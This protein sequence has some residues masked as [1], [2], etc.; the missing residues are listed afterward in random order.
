MR[1]HH[2]EQLETFARAIDHMPSEVDHQVRDLIGAC[3]GAGLNYEVFIEGP[4][5]RGIDPPRVLK[6][7]WGSY[8]DRRSI[9]LPPKGTQAYE[10]HAAYCFCEEKDIWIHARG[11]GLLR[12]AS[13]YEDAYGNRDLPRYVAY[14]GEDS[15]ASIVKAI[16]D[17]EN[18]SR[19]IG[20]FTIES[21][22]HLQYN[23]SAEK[24]LKHLSKIISV[25][26]RT[27]QESWRNNENTRTVADQLRVRL[28]P[29]GVFSTFCQQ[30][31]IFHSHSSRALPDVLEIVSEAVKDISEMTKACH[32]AGFAYQPWSD[33]TRPRNIVTDLLETLRRSVAGIAYLSEPGDD[34]FD[35]NPNVLFEAGIMQALGSPFRGYLLIREISSSTAI[36]FD[37]AQW[38]TILVQRDRVDRSITNRE[39][40][41]DQIRKALR[42]VLEEEI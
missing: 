18:D 1:V 19:V 13:D 32:G 7:Q 5:T 27:A 40:L 3:V 26:A 10:G 39:V 22:N 28:D 6:R 15:R 29:S 17:D 30:P 24:T 35:D 36:P 8:D 33:S 20:V 23:R 2:L 14:T 31:V 16:R 9:V 25:L 41:E 11:G 34:G 4:P 12:D 21:R 38:R 37:L 42:H